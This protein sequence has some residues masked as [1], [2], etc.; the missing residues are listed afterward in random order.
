[1]FKN[2]IADNALSLRVIA[3]KLGCSRSTVSYAL[4]NQA[5]V[6]E[7]TRNKVQALARQLGW[8]PD[9]KLSRQ[10]A[11]VRNSGRSDR[12]NLAIILNKPPCELA[13]EHAPRMHLLGAKSRA[14]SL[15]YNI[16][17]FNLSQQPL[18]PERLMG[19]LAARGIEGVV[20]LATTG[21]GAMLDPKY[22]R[23]GCNFAC[24]VVGIRYTDPQYH[25]AMADQYSSGQIAVSNLLKMGFKRPGAV[26]PRGLDRILSW[27]FGC[28]VQ[29]GTLELPPGEACRSAMSERTRTMCPNLG[30]RKLRI[31]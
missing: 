22:M 15:G 17:E 2:P 25:V 5:A 24:S 28:G 31:G 23:L 19:V 10:L 8:K 16:E 12:P 7:E 1:M 14:I 27:S 3:S 20:Y 29:A 6:S 21:S 9:A 13:E 30:F 4:R 11:L 26:I 18:S